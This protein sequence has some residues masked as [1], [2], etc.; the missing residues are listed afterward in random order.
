VFHG[1]SPDLVGRALPS[2]WAQV[3]PD[4]AM[5]ARDA[6]VE[7]ALDRLVGPPPDRAVELAELATTGCDLAGRPLYAAH[8]AQ[9]RPSSPTLRLWWACT[10]LRE[11]RGDGH[12]AVL[13]AAGIDGCEANQLALLDGVVPADRQ[14]E[15][16]GWSDEAWS[17]AG[18]RA[19]A[20]PAG[21]RAA[22]D[23]ATDRL[24][25]GPVDHLGPAGLDELCD[26]LAPVVAAIA[27]TGLVPYPNPVGVPAPL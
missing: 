13:T 25:S 3:T 14:Q 8:A 5:A 1:F 4:V 2:A 15:V 10:L 9:A 19:R 7:V 26:L 16:R 6:G 20:R 21:F 12:V 24:A 18:E 11:H 27:A 22:I 23:D 17:E